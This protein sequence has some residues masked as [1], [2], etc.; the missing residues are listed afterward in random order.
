MS[1]ATVNRI[2]AALPGARLAG[3]PGELD[4]WKV[5]GRMFACFHEQKGGVALKTDSIAMAQHLIDAGG[6]RSAYYLHPSWVLL[7]FDAP[8]ERQERLI[9]GS[10]DIVRAGLP[11]RVQ[12]SL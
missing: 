8:P 5:G 11:K 6:V 12:A 3:P 7:P 9:R 2:C 10:Y 1:R 4:S